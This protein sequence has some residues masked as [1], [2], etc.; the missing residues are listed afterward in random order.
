M[1]PSLGRF[2]WRQIAW[3]L[4]LLVSLAELSSMFHLYRML[5]SYQRLS[6]QVQSIQEEIF[7]ARRVR[8]TRRLAGGAR[9][10][11]S[12]GGGFVDSVAPGNWQ[13]GGFGLNADGSLFNTSSWGALLAPATN[14]IT[15]LLLFTVPSTEPSGAANN[16][17]GVFT[18]NHLLGDI[19]IIPLQTSNT[20]PVNCVFSLGLYISTYNPTT[21]AWSVQNP[22]T[23]TNA[24]RDDWLWL[25]TFAYQQP[26]TASDNSVFMSNIP[27]NLPLR[28]RLG[29]GQALCLCLGDGTSIIDSSVSCRMVFHLRTHVSRSQ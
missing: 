1:I 28:V 7:M 15:G 18:L 8:G 24:V 21:N 27:I 19:N 14:N 5:R 11:G 6:L 13:V 29:G 17:P 26:V 9:R 10:R 23:P 20:A 16:M 25:R 12:G 22:A 3:L 4:P 2:L